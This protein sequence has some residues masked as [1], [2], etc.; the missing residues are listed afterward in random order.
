MIRCYLFGFILAL[1]AP[2][3]IAETIQQPVATSVIELSA[4]FNQ[5]TSVSAA[6]DGRIFVLDGMNRAIS[7]LDANGKLIQIIKAKG[8]IPDFYQ[9]VGMTWSQGQ[10]F[11]A[12]SLNHRIIVLTDHGELQRI[13]DLEIMIPERDYPE[14]V[15]LIVLDNLLFYS[16][17]HH[18]RFCR[19]KLNKQEK[20]ECFG[21]RGESEKHFQFPFE[22]AADLDN[23]LHIVDVVN[24]RVQVFNQQGH[25]FSSEGQ[26]A[27]NRLYRPNG[28][29][30]DN[31]G[32][33]YV[34]D[35]Y[36]G[37]VSV[38]KNGSYQGE[39][40]NEQGELI[41]Y[42]TPVSLWYDKNSYLLVLDSFS[43][44]L[45]R[46]Q[47]SYQQ[48]DTFQIAPIQEAELSRKN[49]V[50]CHLLWGYADPEISTDEQ[51][52]EPV[53]SLKMCYS[54]HHGVVFESR[55]AIP[56]DG[57]H[58]SVY[59]SKK[60]KQTRQSNLPR[61]DEIPEAHPLMEDGEMLCTACHT[62]HNPEKEQAT[63]Y[64]DN[65]NA[66]LR[67]GNKDS[68]LCESC[69]ESKLESAH[70]RD[71]KLSGLNHPLGFKLE[72]VAKPEKKLHH[73][74]DPH[75]QK[76]LPDSLHAG[77]A[78]LGQQQQMVCQSCHQIHGGHGDDLLAE[79][80]EKDKICGDCHKRQWKTSKK[81]AR[82]AG[83]HPVQVKLEEPV[84]FLGVKTAKVTCESCHRVHD[85]QLNTP[86]LPK[87]IDK[88]EALCVD[89]HERQHA[90]DT[91]DALKKG[92]H[93]VNEELEETVTIGQFKVK[94]M[95]CL[96]CHSIHR[97]KPNTPALIEDHKNGELCENCH[98]D[99]Q[100]IV[101]TDHDLRVTAKD[102]ENQFE[103]KPHQSGVCGACHS[104]HR[105]EAKQPYLFSAIVQSKEHRDET[106]PELKVD[107][108]CMNCHQDEAIGKDKPIEH[109]GHPYKDLILRSD[110]DIMPVVDLKTEKI[111]K[112][113]VIACITCHEPHSWEPIKKNS[114]PL[115]SIP[116]Y[117]QQE[118]QEGTVLNSFL[119]KK[120]VIKTFCVDCHH[121]EGLA[122]F[123]YYHDEKK[124]RDI[125]V[126]Y[127]K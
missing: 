103:E 42:H 113:G 99:K 7:V 30:I 18:H 49:C 36:L 8:Q 53:A 25:Y 80:E 19:I 66:W 68:E 83:V 124:V 86:L 12:D 41:K 54:C 84:K 33:Q 106:A 123:K 28:I 2:L 47:L 101:G 127:L 16:D 117:H 120:G 122:K 15:S 27:V 31:L 126:D 52:S 63:L 71:A 119:R 39:L 85:G 34:S 43:G 125:G 100:R 60:E 24:G 111:E 90:K 48:H 37:T 14:P 22:I 10:I 96:S 20:P 105:G 70:E 1:V 92:I 76:G 87:Q 29:A 61:E 32:Y 116:D 69:H 11:I 109:Y 107:E 35:A 82:K 6:D 50:A 95:G 97:G 98:A 57:Q 64:S 79:T 56:F 81:S 44:S 108:L 118:N 73:S 75:L 115:K 3:L 13:I 5:P 104:L 9:A 114:P 46:I 121:I 65:Q 74:K 94:Q 62:P 88:V 89:C 67:V 4:Q 93:P 55:Q 112:L 40:K 91:E 102:S 59:D 17:R 78:M 72:K 23:Y 110:E 58:P 21:R 51:G 45:H 26:F 77:G 38:F